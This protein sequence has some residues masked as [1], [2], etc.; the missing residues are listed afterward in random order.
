VPNIGVFHPQ[1]VH[2]AIALLS[3]GVVFRLVSLTGKLTFTGPSAAALILAGT[4]AAVAAAT[5]GTQAHDPVERIPGARAAVTEHEEWG[6][7]TR[8]LFLAVAALEIV[9]LVTRRRGWQRYVLFASAAVGLV[10]IGF[11][12]ETG[13]HG[14]HIVY[15]YAGGVGTRSGDPADVDHLLLAGLYQRA[16]LDR[17]DGNAEDAASLFEELKRRFPDD[18]TIRLL[19]IESQLLDRHDPEAALTALRE[20][21]VPSD[22]RMVVY[23]TGLLRADVFDALHQPDSTRAVLE[24]LVEKFPTNAGLKD[25]LAKLQ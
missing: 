21:V 22:N 2:F 8:N 25:R 20:F 12:Y 1:I 3:A 24:A 17:K 14:G 15:G 13:E 23:R 11:I 4:L 10:G 5:S 19:A 16:M 6:E 9:A 7:R 18:P